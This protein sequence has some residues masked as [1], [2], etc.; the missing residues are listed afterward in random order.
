MVISKASI[1]VA[2]CCT[3]VIMDIAGHIVE[4]HGHQVNG[5]I[6]SPDQKIMDQIHIEK[7]CGQEKAIMEIT[8]TIKNVKLTMTVN[9]LTRNVTANAYY[10]FTNRILSKIYTILF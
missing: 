4:L 2:M 5:V 3:V 7:R 1:K 10:N 9:A 8:I 6:Q